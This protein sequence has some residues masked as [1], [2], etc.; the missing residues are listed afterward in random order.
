MTGSEA[1]IRSLIE[2]GV[3][4]IFGYPGGAIMPV[5]DALYDHQDTIHHVL[6]RHE[7]GAAHAAQG[8]AR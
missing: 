8:Y 5:Y 4:T 3:E 1:L 7:Q 6:T 2:E